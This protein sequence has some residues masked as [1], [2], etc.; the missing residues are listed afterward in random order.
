MI[1]TFDFAKLNWTETSP[2]ISQKGFES[3]G[4]RFRLVE[5]ATDAKHDEWCARGHLGY[6]LEGAIEFET[7][8]EK[9]LVKAGEAF[10]I[11]EGDP[12]RARNAASTPSRFFLSD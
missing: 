12:H 3:G 9:F 5:Y 7:P 11:P 10:R 4:Q 2:G 8:S 1:E 6:V